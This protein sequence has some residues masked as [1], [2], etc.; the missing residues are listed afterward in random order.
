M[1]TSPDDPLAAFRGDAAISSISQNVSGV[2]SPST[3][4]RISQSATADQ[5]AGDPLHYAAYGITDRNQERLEIR[6]VL[7]AWHAPGYR[8]LMDVVYNAHQGS[9]LV[10][11]Y[12]FMAVTIAGRN[13]QPIMA[14]ILEGTCAFIQDYHEQEFTPP[15]KDT[16]II[17][18]IELLLRREE[19]S[20]PKK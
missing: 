3:F 4:Q 2:F 6:R 5:M 20:E 14:A 9:E 13:M 18:K 11:T 16:P 1:S 17:T 10:L 19:A 7:G 15:D 12:S 8:Y